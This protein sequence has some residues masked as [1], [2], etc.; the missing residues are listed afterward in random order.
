[1]TYSEVATMIEAMGV[2]YA[3]YQ[4]DA[5]TAQAPPFICF[6]Y[7]GNEDLIADNINY[8]KIERLIIEL[9]TDEKDFTMEAAVEGILT[10]Y[11][12]PYNKAETYIDSERLYEVIYETTVVITDDAKSSDIVGKAAADFAII[13]R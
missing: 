4:F 1:M 10:N 5:K 9:Y 7:S 11:E 8:Q 3:Y 2:P 12:Q 13:R 6:Y